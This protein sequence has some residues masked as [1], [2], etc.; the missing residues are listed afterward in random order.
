MTELFNNERSD[1][2]T[3]N[4]TGTVDPKGA[5]ESLVGEGK[6][7]ATPEMLAAGK[8][9]SDRFIDQLTQE[10]K[11]LRAELN[12][13]LTAEQLLDK[14][15]ERNQQESNRQNAS[16]N[17]PDG[18]QGNP[19][20]LTE[21]A[22]ANLVQKQMQMHNEKTREQANTAVV[23]QELKKQYGDS[24]QRN[25]EARLSELGITKEAAG[26]MA[27]TMPKAFIELVGKPKT[28]PGP[29]GGLPPRTQV[30]T[31]VTDLQTNEVKNFAYYEKMR[32]SPDKAIQKLYW[33]PKIQNEMFAS[34]RELGEDFNS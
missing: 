26:Q 1:Y 32:K 23:V 21:E 10:N 7:F 4:D 5:L 18:S 24:Y 14:F 9:E 22:I 11:N 25:L 34:A 12:E 29:T 20:G 2:A 19:S 30:N 15:N 33:S 31:S 8:L 28:A 3:H 27:A 16:G 17:Q 6:K 13:R